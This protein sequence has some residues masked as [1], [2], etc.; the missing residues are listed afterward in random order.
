M[1]VSEA[2]FGAVEEAELVAVDEVDKV[3]VSID[4]DRSC[5]KDTD[6]V[7]DT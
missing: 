4:G 5:D 6:D 3:G 7:L 1:E 2:L